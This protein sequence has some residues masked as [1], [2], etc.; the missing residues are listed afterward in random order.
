[1]IS[2]YALTAECGAFEISTPLNLHRGYLEQH[3]SNQLKSTLPVGVSATPWGPHIGAAAAASVGST[4]GY[5]VG[6]EEVGGVIKGDVSDGSLIDN[7][8]TSSL[9]PADAT[10]E[11]KVVSIK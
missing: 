6:G 2:K 8:D 3:G 1:M 7:R 9:S 10:P 11:L 4:T 5:I